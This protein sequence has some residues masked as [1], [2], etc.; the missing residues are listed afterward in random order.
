MTN[1]RA[2][3]VPAAVLACASTSL[4]LFTPAPAS[5]C[6]TFLAQDGDQAVFGKSY[7]WTMDQGLVLVNKRDVAKSAVTLASGDVPATWTSRYASLTF[8]QYG[9]E[10]PNGGVNEAGLVVEIMWL[11]SSVY[12]AVDQRKAMSELQWIQFVL[13]QYGNVADLAAH[14]DEVR[15]D[16]VYA[17]VH[18]LACDTSHACAAFEYVGGKLVVTT[19]AAMPVKTLTNDTYA[20]SA[21][22]LANYSGFGSTKP[23]PTSESSLD[24]FVRAS[25]LVLAAPVPG[26]DLPTKAFS[27]LDSVRQ[28]GQGSTSQWN[29][30]YDPQTTQVRFR[31]RAHPSIKSVTLRGFDGSCKAPVKMFD[32]ASDAVGAVD[33]AFTDYTDAADLALLQKSL[34]P[35]GDALPPGIDQLLV[36][37]AASLA[38]TSK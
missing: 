6:T 18:Y 36:Q 24:R 33:A 27:I 5:A 15:V 2:S 22:Y 30:V 29:I 23:I 12:P 1:F 25:S 14:I 26:V 7:D 3:F 32:M 9:R 34:A 13:D 21:A 28:D 38:C 37:Y 10:F 35:I 11:D 19:G 8:N 31:T 16:P 20:D 17:R 4:A